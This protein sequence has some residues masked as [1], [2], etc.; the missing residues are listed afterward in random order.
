MSELYLIQRSLLSGVKEPMVTFGGK[1]YNS[2][3]LNMVI[4]I[5]N[6]LGINAQTSKD[7]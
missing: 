2:L 3:S 6:S 5:G 1:V 4:C 7:S